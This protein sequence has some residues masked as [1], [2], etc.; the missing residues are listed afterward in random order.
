MIDYNSP[1]KKVWE[2]KH[3]NQ[4][5]L[6][7]KIFLDRREGQIESW[8][9]V[10]IWHLFT[11]NRSR[12]LNFFCKTTL[13]TFRCLLSRRVDLPSSLYLGRALEWRQDTVILDQKIHRLRSFNTSPQSSQL[14]SFLICSFAALNLIEWFWPSNIPTNAPIRCTIHSVLE[15]WLLQGSK[16][17]KSWE[18]SGALWWWGEFEAL[19]SLEVK[20][21]CRVLPNI[22][23]ISEHIEHPAKRIGESNS[24]QHSIRDYQMQSLMSSQ[25]IHRETG[26]VFHCSPWWSAWSEVRR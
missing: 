24:L 4:K 14:I 1:K 11:N 15:H 12:K 20:Y 25:F 13:N 10:R 18:Q 6:P 19:I 23:V 17:N 16:Y 9:P 3:W 22:L 2:L 26:R 21:N 7:K 5:S 8:M